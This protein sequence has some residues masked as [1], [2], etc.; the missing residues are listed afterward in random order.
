MAR[1]EREVRAVWPCALRSVLDDAGHGLRDQLGAEEPAADL[2]DTLL[3]KLIS[4]ELH[5][6][7]AEAAFAAAI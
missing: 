2:R 7:N 5:V 1:R 6:K 4:G 3:P